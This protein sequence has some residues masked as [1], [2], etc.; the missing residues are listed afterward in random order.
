MKALFLKN[1]SRGPGHSIRPAIRSVAGFPGRAIIL[2]AD[3]G[4]AD[5]AAS[6]RAH[7]RGAGSFASRGS[8]PQDLLGLD[9]LELLL[10]RE[11]ELVVSPN[12]RS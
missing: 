3:V 8:D 6:L 11:L 5:A 12:R 7:G 2:R 10:G 9:E 4:E 1:S